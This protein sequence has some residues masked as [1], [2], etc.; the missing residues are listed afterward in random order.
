MVQESRTITLSKK[1]LIG[2]FESHRRM[3]PHFLPQGRI[4]ECRTTA[5]GTIVLTFAATSEK[6]APQRVTL[7]A[8]DTLKPLIRFCIENNVILPTDGQKSVHVTSN[9]AS[10]C[11]SLDLNISTQNFSR[12]M[13]TVDFVDLD[14]ATLASGEIKPRAAAPAM[15]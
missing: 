4:T 13:R 11:V 1:E 6:V 5:E 8:S 14:D 10:L 12:A 3:T 7:K 2:A 15:A 9:S